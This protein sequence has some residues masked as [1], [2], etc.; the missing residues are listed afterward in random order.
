[1]SNGFDNW[2][3]ACEYFIQHE[4]SIHREAVLKRSLTTQQTVAVQL[5]NRE[6]FVKQLR[7]LLRQGLA[8]RGHEEKQVNLMQLLLLRSDDCTGL[9]Q[10]VEKGN[11]TSHDI[12]HELMANHILREILCE[13]RETSVFC[14]IFR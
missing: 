8:L 10:C 11:Y 2:K 7:Y 1:M 3:K 12:V 14:L 5:L 9:E 4:K 6:M 13:I